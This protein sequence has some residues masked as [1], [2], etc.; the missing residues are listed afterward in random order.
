MAAKHKTINRDQGLLIISI[1]YFVERRS[2]G[3][4]L[5]QLNLFDDYKPSS[6]SNYVISAVELLPV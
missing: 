5:M 2:L 1:F 3:F 4:H 6:Y